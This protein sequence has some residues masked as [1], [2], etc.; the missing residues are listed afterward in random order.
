ME[1][2][3]ELRG[4]NLEQWFKDRLKEGLWAE[5]QV[6]KHLM[7]KGWTIIEISEGHF[8]EW[9]IKATIN[10]EIKTFEVKSNYF[11]IKNYRHNMVVIE[12]ESNGEASG[13]SVTTA[14]FYVLFY[15]FEDFFYIER[16]EDIKKMIHSGLYSK[17]VGGRKN[18]AVMWQIPRST[19]TNKK[20]LRFMDYLDEDTKSQSW[21]SWYEYKYLHNPYNLM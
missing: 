8:K 20:T 21:W 11:E 18:L 3:S 9:D 5:N 12:T 14:D 10:E 7:S 17:V 6:A 19:F 1:N 15:P 13:L 16:V 2:G 4:E